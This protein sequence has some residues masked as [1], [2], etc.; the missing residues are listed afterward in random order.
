MR[1]EKSPNVTKKFIVKI[2]WKKVQNPNNSNSPR[3][4]LTIFAKA[5]LKPMSKNYYL[6]S[7]K[8]CVFAVAILIFFSLISAF[9]ANLNNCTNA[10]NKRKIKT[11]LNSKN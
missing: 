11:F 6:I 7:I 8:F 3:F 4:C 9:F 2:H 1:E 5:F 10:Q